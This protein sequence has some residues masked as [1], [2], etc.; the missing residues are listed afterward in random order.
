[1]SCNR[2]K[3]DWTLNTS[4]ERASFINEYTT[5]LAFTP[6][7]EELE[8]M[9]NYILW[10][11]DP[12]G[13]NS[14]QKGFVQLERRNSTWST[15]Q[16]TNVGSLDE[17][18][19]TPTF[20]ESELRQPNSPVYKT[21]KQN[22]SREEA[23]HRAPPHILPVLLDLFR[24]IDTLDLQINFY[25][26]DHG[27]RKNPPRD[28][29]LNVFTPDE[30]DALKARTKKWNQRTYLKRRHLLVELRREQYTYRDFYAEPISLHP[31]P[32]NWDLEELTLDSEIP[33]FPLGLHKDSPLFL[34][35]SQLCQNSQDLQFRK[36]IEQLK[37]PSYT[38]NFSIDFRD[39]E[40]IYILIT[41]YDE[42]RDTAAA[43]MINHVDSPIPNLLKTLEYYISNTILS[44]SQRDILSMKRAG[45]KNND[46][47]AHINST[48]NKTYTA[49][50]ISTI[51]HKKILP[52]IANAATYH[53]KLYY[54]LNDPL[55]FKR[56]STCGTYYLRSEDNF[57]RKTRARDGFANRCKLCDK[58]AR[59][60]AKK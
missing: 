54:A 22:F 19:E 4:D 48:Y 45:Q 30:L 17:L 52:A 40:Q 44:D 16:S 50:Y 55:N 49:N 38:S 20:N 43:L 29:L 34:P 57:V 2:L 31:A 24:R 60:S 28:S 5:S 9:G 13:Q 56:C 23:L 21:P 46:I 18:L 7:E 47:V 39:P 37:L 53:E 51:Y 32:P 41:Q 6:N 26:L 1:M 35:F 33:I 27:K 59:A 58:L 15:T 14:E 3:L 8:M 10:G 11:R 36:S 12:D 25:E 42:L